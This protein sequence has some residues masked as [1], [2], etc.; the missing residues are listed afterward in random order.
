MTSSS[1]TGGR[2]FDTGRTWLEAALARPD[3]PPGHAL[4]ARTMTALADAA[5]RLEARPVR[6][7]VYRTDSPDE[8]GGPRWYW[9]CPGCDAGGGHNCRHDLIHPPGTWPSAICGAFHHIHTEH[10]RP[11]DAEH[12]VLGARRRC[13]W[14]PPSDA[15]LRYAILTLCG[16]LGYPRS[17][18]ARETAREVMA[19]AGR[20]PP[21]AP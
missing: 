6:A 9:H 8:V 19:L 10:P 12:T 21:G 18:L 7:R 13:D 11:P 2:S 17:A 3:P 20:R 14:T 15:Q 5:G 1:M 4:T 16:R